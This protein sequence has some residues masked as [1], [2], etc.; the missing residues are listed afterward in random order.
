MR[1]FL[2]VVKEAGDFHS[3]GEF[4][5]A[6]D[7]Y[8][9]LLGAQ[10][11]DP[12]VLYL[13]GTLNSQ[14]GRF[15]TAI[16]L[17]LRSSQL[18]GAELPEVWHNLGVAYRNEGHTEDARNAY[19]KAL[20]LDPNR[21]DTLA[22]MAGSYVNTG[23]P[24]AAIEWAD[25]ALAIHDSAHARNHKSLACLEANR[26]AEAWPLYESRFELD[27]F[28]AMKR[29][30]EVPRWDGSRVRKLAIHGE[31]GLGDEILFMSCFDDAADL[32]DEIVVECA[33][34]LLPL[35]ERSFQVLCYATHDE[36]ISANSD[37]DAYI[38]MGSLPGLF[39]LDDEDFPRVPFLNA[40]AALAD[41]YSKRFPR[42][43]VGIA[44]HG[45][46]KGTHQELRN[47]P[48]DLWRGL[49]QANQDITWVSLQY[50]A[51]GPM[52]ASELRILHDQ[53]AIDNVDRQAALIASCDLV[54]SVCQT[55][56]HIA[57]GLGVPCWC[58][59][60]DHAAWRYGTGGPMLWYPE[61]LE[62]IRQDGKGWDGVFETVGDRLND[63]FSDTGD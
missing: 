2:D 22:M 16:N 49:I 44:W 17:L 4:D 13:L 50:G 20:D 43:V 62:L 25:K 53:E 63:Y 27:S 5:K 58:L 6:Q 45:G 18:Q 41:E 57:G 7:L 19:R 32:A 29:P 35:F 36:L 3:A 26:W 28:S 59:T 1:S 10:P 9:A 14:R 51:D 21:Q 56:I 33:G 30:Y 8:E 42:P 61:S 24:E 40:D 12:I 31:Q 38:P 54:I 47:A 55:A 52:Q 46:T 15:G 48:L 11:D 39:R 23:S 37:I 60:P 34:R